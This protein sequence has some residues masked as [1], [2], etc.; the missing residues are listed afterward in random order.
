MAGDQKQGAHTSSETSE[1]NK[2][3]KIQSS[4]ALFKIGSF[5]YWF[6]WSLKKNHWRCLKLSIWQ[7]PRVYPLYESFTTFNQILGI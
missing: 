3:Q 6:G 5:F 4:W 2:L 1:K 7:E